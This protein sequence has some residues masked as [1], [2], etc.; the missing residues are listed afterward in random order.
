MIAPI[1]TALAALLLLAAS[2]PA[3]PET[4]VY[5]SN[6]EMAAIYAADQADRQPGAAAIDWSVVEPRDRARQARTRALLD[7]GALQSGDDFW[8]A[9]YVFQHGSEPNDYLLAHTLAMI[10][11]ARGRDD[12]IWIAAAT[13]DRY[14]QKSSRP[15]IY[16]TQFNPRNPMTAR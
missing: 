9:A 14:L 6:A 12:A 13:L 15:Q 8:H 3:T 2:P 4:P 7:A 5:P 1:R 16:G 10:A 11:T